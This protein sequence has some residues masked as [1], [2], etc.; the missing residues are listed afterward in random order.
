[1]A[2]GFAVQA[3]E[4]AA[5]DACARLPIS[6]VGRT[7]AL[8]SRFFSDDPW[9]L[10]DDSA[11]ASVVGPGS[12]RES[13]SLDPEITLEWGW[14]AGAFRIDVRYEPAGADP[15]ERRG[16]GD[17]TS[18]HRRRRDDPS[19]GSAGPHHQDASTATLAS[20]FDGA[21]VPE[22]QPADT[23]MRF[24]TGP[25]SGG[26]SLWYRS[27][28][29][30]VDD[31]VRGLFAAFADDLAGV[32]LGPGS[33]LVEIRD[34]SRWRD[35][36]LP[37]LGLVADLFAP[38]RPTAQPDRQAERAHEEL[39][40]L[41]AENPRDLARICDALTSPDT[42]YREIAMSLLAGADPFTAERGWRAALDDGSRSVRRSAV[43]SMANAGSP[44][45]RPLLE[46]ALADSDACVRYHAVRGLARLSVARS[47]TLIAAHERDLDGRV[48]LAAAAALAGHAIP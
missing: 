21:V 12:G 40:G 17:P 7:R 45:V 2:R 43:A 19:G 6:L 34:A 38:P 31:R 5:R 44:Q 14:R 20:T 48:R 35:L 41:D 28:A 9:G 11:L 39:S 4:H 29:D 37:M 24:L 23:T 1:M 33:V 25:G 26:S 32:Q 30:A 13:R 27:P 16:T 15:D 42:A 46:R 10:E 47:E 8:L 36:M 22:T 3:T 18:P